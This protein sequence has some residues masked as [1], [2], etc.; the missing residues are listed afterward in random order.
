MGA[1]PFIPR[2]SSQFSQCKEKSDFFGTALN[3]THSTHHLSLEE[4]SSI[5]TFDQ[6]RKGHSE[7]QR[8]SCEDSSSSS[9]QGTDFSIA[10]AEF[11][12]SEPNRGSP[13][14][15]SLG[16]PFAPAARFFGSLELSKLSSQVSSFP[17]PLCPSL[18]SRC[19]RQVRSYHR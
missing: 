15:N 16:S 19:L 6:A 3:Q 7:A 2:V 17:P 10:E 4:T 12:C 18:S 1:V 5:H 14:R 9:S 11:P 13:I 8:H